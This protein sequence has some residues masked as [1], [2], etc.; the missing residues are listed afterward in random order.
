MHNINVLPVDIHDVRIA[1]YDFR[2]VPPHIIHM[3]L[4]CP[5]WRGAGL[6]P[7]HFSRDTDA[8]IL[9]NT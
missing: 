7:F 2:L 4:H 3:D 1:G 5:Y 8:M 9:I 6:G